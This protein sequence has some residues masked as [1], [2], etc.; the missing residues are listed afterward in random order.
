MLIIN[1]NQNG[2]QCLE[3]LHAH[4]TDFFLFVSV[5]FDVTTKHNIQL[6][7]HWS[8]DFYQTKKM[9]SYLVVVVL[10]FISKKVVNNLREHYKN[11]PNAKYF[12]SLNEYVAAVR[13]IL[14]REKPATASATV[15]W[16]KMSVW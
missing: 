4:G 3:K 16:G 7:S 1:G 8:D 14:K 10:F 9:Q 5:F 15:H 11:F 12:E 2:K 6:F 13:I